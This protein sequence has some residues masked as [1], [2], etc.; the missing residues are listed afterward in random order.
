MQKAKLGTE[1]SI[2]PCHTNWSD[3]FT[4]RPSTVGSM[5]PKASSS[6]PVAVTT[7]SASS[8]RPDASRIPSGTKRS[9]R[10]VT[11]SASPLFRAW[12]RSASGTA[13]SRWSQ[14]S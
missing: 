13:Q 5:P 3:N 6:S 10:S 2:V 11:I 14:G 9:M 12:K 8:T 7:T 1:V 4:G